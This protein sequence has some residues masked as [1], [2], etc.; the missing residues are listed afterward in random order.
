M[1]NPVNRPLAAEAGKRKID[2]RAEVMNMAKVSKATKG[3][4]YEVNAEFAEEM[5]AKNVK[6]AAQNNPSHG[7]EK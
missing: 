5:E 4:K 7:T 6:H 1:S 2:N 3:K